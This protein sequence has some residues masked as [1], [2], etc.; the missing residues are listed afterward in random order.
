[1]RG[2][3]TNR[4]ALLDSI[5]GIA[6]ISMILYHGIWNLV[7]IYGFDWSWYKG[8]GAWLWQQSIC[9]TFILLSGFCW[10]IGKRR[11]K[12]G[13]MVFGGGLLVTAVTLW[14]MPQNRVVFGVLT[15]IGSCILLLIP[16]ERFLRHLSFEWGM[17]VSFLF[18]GLTRGVNRG[19]LGLGKMGFVELPNSWYQG[20]LGAYLGFPSPSFYSTDYFPLIPWFFL[21]L[22]GY[23]FYGIC[24]K[25]SWFNRKIFRVCI[26]A[27]EVL[28]RNSLLIYLLH[29]PILY[30]VESIILAGH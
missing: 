25:R 5:R 6:L 8:K 29:Q 14:S 3:R 2:G 28:G 11:L 20:N 1:M 17:A 12:N 30:F 7:Y 27:A 13:L 9:W 22:T 19:Y 26:P 23:F 21:F 4:Y 16:L 15:C 24:Q 18:F 10:S